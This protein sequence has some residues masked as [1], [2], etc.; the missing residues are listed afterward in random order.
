MGSGHASGGQPEV[1]RLEDTERA[2]RRFV[3]RLG[4]AEGLA[5]GARPAMSFTG[6]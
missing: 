1:V 5:V 2:I 6:C 3:E 4:G